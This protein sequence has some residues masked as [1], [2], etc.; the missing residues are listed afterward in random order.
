LAA[1]T[2]PGEFR[3]PTIA[4]RLLNAVFGWLVGLGFGLEHNYLLQVAGRRSG[5][6]YRTPVNVLTLDGRRWLVAPRGRTQWVRN[7]EVSGTAVLRRGRRFE[8]VRLRVVADA[9]KPPILGAYLDRFRT[10]VQRHFPVTAGSPP[11]AFVSLAPRYPVFEI[12]S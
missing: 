2:A 5:R 12:T 6:I 3:A 9:D 10:T 8:R 11:Q 4:E 7:V 1:E